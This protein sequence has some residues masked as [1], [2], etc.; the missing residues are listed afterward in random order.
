MKRT[1]STAPFG[2]GEAALCSPSCTAHLP[3]ERPG[4]AQ[5]VAHAFGGGLPTTTAHSKLSTA[6]ITIPSLMKT[7]RTPSTQCQLTTSLGATSPWL[8][9][10]SKDTDPKT[11]WAAVPTHH[12]SFREETAPNK[13]PTFLGLDRPISKGPLQALGFRVVSH[14]EG[15]CVR[16]AALRPAAA[17]GTGPAGSRAVSAAG[18]RRPSRSAASR[19]G[20][21]ALLR[22]TLRV[23][24]ILTSL[25]TPPKSTTVLSRFRSPRSRS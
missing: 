17:L 9:N 6:V 16:G 14:K 8:Q 19:L 10:T 20:P 18:T 12:R 2:Q 11:P 23:P 3:P 15:L 1:T 25:Q 7:F 22:K 13:H 24:S 21:A 4:M 5:G